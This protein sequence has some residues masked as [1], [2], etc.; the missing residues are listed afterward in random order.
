M[1]APL[2][3]MQRFAIPGEG[4]LLK[5]PSTGRKLGLGSQSSGGCR[6]IWLPSRRFDGVRQFSLQA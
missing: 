3:F 6:L 5:M 1:L 2:A 4:P